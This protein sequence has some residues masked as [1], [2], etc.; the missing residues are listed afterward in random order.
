ML[1]VAAV[2]VVDFFSRLLGFTTTA[3]SAFIEQLFDFLSLCLCFHLPSIPLAELSF[4]L[5][6]T[7]FLT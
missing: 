4:F 6:L 5:I 3:C 2:L 7:L 1:A